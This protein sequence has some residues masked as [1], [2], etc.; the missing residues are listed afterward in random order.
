VAAR[1]RIPPEQIFPLIEALTQQGQRWLH[2]TGR[3]E[4][5]QNWAPHAPSE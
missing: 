4:P 3:S 5:P 2:E 1:V